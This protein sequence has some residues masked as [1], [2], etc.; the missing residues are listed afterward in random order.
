VLA[1]DGKLLG[2]I[3]AEILRTTAAEPGVGDFALAAD[4]M[5][6]PFAVKPSDDLRRALEVIMEHGVREI[7]VV[8]DG[9]RI[10]GFLDE[11]DITRVYHEATR[12]Q[13]AGPGAP[14]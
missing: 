13:Q 8:D 10:V 3:T 4:M 11:A 7:I 6:P 1:A 9:G 14:S 12:A 2:V 5:S